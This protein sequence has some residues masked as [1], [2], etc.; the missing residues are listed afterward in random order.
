MWPVQGTRGRREFELIKNGQIFLAMTARQVDIVRGDFV[1]T[2]FI[3]SNADGSLALV[4]GTSLVRS[5]S[6]GVQPAVRINTVRLC[7]T[8]AWVDLTPLDVRCFKRLEHANT[9]RDRLT[10][11]RTG[12][13]LPVH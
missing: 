9:Y 2:F 11:W 1:F 12:G 7:L 8:Q 4:C 3:H 13:V 10:R 6:D 5:H